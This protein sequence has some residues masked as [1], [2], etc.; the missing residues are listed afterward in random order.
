LKRLHLGLLSLGVFGLVWK[1]FHLG[2]S[3]SLNLLGEYDLPLLA[4]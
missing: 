3:S 4:E 2:F 1:A